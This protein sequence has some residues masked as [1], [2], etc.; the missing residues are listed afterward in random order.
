MFSFVCICQPVCSPAGGGG[1]GGGAVPTYNFYHIFSQKLF[2]I[3]KILVRRGERVSRA[4]P[5]FH[6]CHVTIIYDA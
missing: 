3:E 5:W 6:H 1:G 2:E 4:P